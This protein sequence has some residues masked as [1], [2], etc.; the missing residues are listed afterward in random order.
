[1]SYCCLVH[2]RRKIFNS[3]IERVNVESSW[4][5]KLAQGVYQAFF[6]LIKYLTKQLRKKDFLC[7][8]SGTQL[9]D[10]SLSGWGRHDCKWLHSGWS[11]RQLST[12]CHQSLSREKQEVWLDHKNL[13]VHLSDLLPS[14]GLHFQQVPQPPQTMSPAGLQVF[15]HKSLWGTV[16]IQS[17]TGWSWEDLVWWFFLVASSR[18]K[19]DDDEPVVADTCAVVHGI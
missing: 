6:S 4:S 5:P 8:F 9:R 12:F 16:Y 17:T 7:V 10:R 11:T 18:R 3:C 15:K 14:A 1:M 19:I 2:E 13:K